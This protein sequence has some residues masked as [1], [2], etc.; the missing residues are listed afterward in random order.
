MDE[1]GYKIKD[2]EVS[3]IDEEAKIIVYARKMGN[4][5]DT[6]NGLEKIL[7]PD[8]LEISYEE[9]EAVKLA[10]MNVSL[11]PDSVERYV[12]RI[13]E[14]DLEEKIRKKFRPLY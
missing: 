5:K 13:E 4:L 9:T 10:I 3:I 6:M 12:G 1:K 11:D 7:L 8:T 14:N 2:A